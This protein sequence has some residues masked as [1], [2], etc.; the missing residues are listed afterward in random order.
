MKLGIF[1]RRTSV[2][3]WTRPSRLPPAT[4]YPACSSTSP[5]V[6]LKRF[7]ASLCPSR[8]A[9]RLSVPLSA[10]VSK[11]QRFLELSTWLTR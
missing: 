6:G 2:P 9:L 5:V 3:L 8:S 11:S 10:M 1:A 7:P 4:G